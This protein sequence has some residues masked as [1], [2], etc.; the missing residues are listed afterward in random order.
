M[1]ELSIMGNEHSHQLIQAFGGILDPGKYA[2][3]KE[4]SPKGSLYYLLKKDKS[5]SWDIKYRIGMDIDYG[6][7]YLHDR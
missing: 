1:H 3:V 5:F 6:L 4:L 7:K 2:I